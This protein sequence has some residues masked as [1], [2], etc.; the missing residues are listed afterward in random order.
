MDI[1]IDPSRCYDVFLQDSGGHGVGCYAWT[2]VVPKIQRDA[3]G[4]DPVKL[5]GGNFKHFSIFI[6]N[7]GEDD[8]I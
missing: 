5:V 3:R 4:L 1:H 7:L 2:R 8:P 6:S